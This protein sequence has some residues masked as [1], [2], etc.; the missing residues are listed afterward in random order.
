[1]KI[2]IDLGHPAHIHYFRNFISQ[3]QARGHEF[4]L[5][6]RD[7]EVLHELLQRYN[8]AYITRGKGGN[9]L[10]G[11]LLYI[12]KADV[13]IYKAARK[14]KPDLFLS[15]ASTYAAHAAWLSRRPH[16]ALD[17]TEHAS[18]EIMLYSPFTSVIVNPASFLKK[19]SRRQL[20][21]ETFFELNYLHPRYFTPDH[22]IPALYNIDI[23]Q[24]YFILRF[25]SWNASHDIGQSGLTI[26]LKINIAK[27]LAEKGRVLISSEEEL[28][29]ELKKYQ[30]KIDP[31][32]LHDLLAFSALYVGE[33]ATTAAECVVLGVPAI[34]VNSLDAGTL[35]EYATKYGLISL[36]NGNELPQIIDTYLEHV[37]ENRLK[38]LENKK[39]LLAEKIDGTKFLTWFVE[40]YPASEKELRANSDLQYDLK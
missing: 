27:K 18:F 38:M 10:L 25:V 34:Y 2:L 9:N 39:Q 5:V 35:Q 6:A 37:N 1:M 21:V 30:L 7:K 32:H 3:M 4:L 11:K 16:I 13:L 17:D 40:N 12:L 8:F 29:A 33:G 31:R 22:S 19:F 36:R 14:F 26:D 20:F 15:F 23:K 24:T 28:P